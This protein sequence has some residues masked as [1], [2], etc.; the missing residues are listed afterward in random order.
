MEP[1][2]EVASL[3]LAASPMAEVDG[4]SVKARE[5]AYTALEVREVELVG[6]SLGSL[7]LPVCLQPAVRQMV[8]A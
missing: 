6:R 5:L 7:V 2:Q 1:G 8:S 3:A 4:L